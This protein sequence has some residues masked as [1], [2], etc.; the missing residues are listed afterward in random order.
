[1]TKSFDALAF[2][3][4]AQDRIYEQVKGMNA[5]EEVGYFQR[6]AEAGELGAWWRKVK[7]AQ[8]A[9]KTPVVGQGKR[10]G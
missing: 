9:A 7:G 5:A 8:E 2:K 6:T 4:Q 10:D 1:M 3:W